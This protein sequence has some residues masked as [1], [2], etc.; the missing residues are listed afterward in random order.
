[1]FDNPKQVLNAWLE[2]V[3]AGDP[4]SVLALYCKDAVLL[5]TFADKVFADAKS[6]ESYFLRLADLGVES[7]VLRPETLSVQDFAA[8]VFSLSGFYDWKFA[9]GDKIA[10]R[11]TFTVDVDQPAPILH[12]HSSVLPKAAG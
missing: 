12:H 8:G 4:D 11:F 10:A 5:P 6:I 2:G 1:M 9:N 3:N 7:V